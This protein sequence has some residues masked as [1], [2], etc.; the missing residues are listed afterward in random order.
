MMVVSSGSME[1]NAGKCKEM[2]LG[3]V[4]Y[5]VRFPL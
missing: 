5:L 1:V 4:Y 2:N 3:M